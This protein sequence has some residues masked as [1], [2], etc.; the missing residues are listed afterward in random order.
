MLNLHQGDDVEDD[1]NYGTSLTSCRQGRGA[2]PDMLMNDGFL[3]P[4]DDVDDSSI[5]SI[6]DTEV[7]GFAQIFDD[8]EMYFCDND[9][10]VDFMNSQF[11]SGNQPV[12]SGDDTVVVD[13]VIVGNDILP[14]LVELDDIEYGLHYVENNVI[15]D[16]QTLFLESLKTASKDEL[17]KVRRKKNSDPGGI[18][19]WADTVELYAF[20]C[21]TNLSE[22]KPALSN[23]SPSSFG[24]SLTR[25]S[26]AICLISFSLKPI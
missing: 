26:L 14:S 8:S 15:F 6:V 18:R 5:G 7:D 4:V 24:P 16:Y 9:E 11:E 12:D 19:H 22:G 17:I 2:V 1:Y 10:N 20:A 21:E 13:D 25:Y 3:V 23:I